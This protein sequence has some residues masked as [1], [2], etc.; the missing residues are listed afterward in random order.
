MAA[1]ASRMLLEKRVGPGPDGARV[2]EQLRSVGGDDAHRRSRLSMSRVHC[3]G[4]L[5]SAVRSHMSPSVGLV[6]AGQRSRTS[7]R[8]PLVTW[9]PLHRAGPQYGD[10]HARAD[11][12]WPGH[13]PQLRKGRGGDHAQPQVDPRA[14]RRAHSWQAA[15][16]PVIPNVNST[17][18]GCGARGG[19]SL[20]I[21]SGAT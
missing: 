4:G 7:S 15:G 6:A 9:T 20:R 13:D 14:V 10:A 16:S 19:A 1:A 12:P 18:N 17:S 8:W 2:Q 3:R 21:R 5:G 11:P